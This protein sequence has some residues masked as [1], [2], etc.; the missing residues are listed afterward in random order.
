VS[1]KEVDR[2]PWP[3]PEPPPPSQA[4]KNNPNSRQSST[5]CD[6]LKRPVT[7]IIL[8]SVFGVGRLPIACSAPQLQAFV[9]RSFD[10]G[11]KSIL[12]I[13]HRKNL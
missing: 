13:S 11:N 12:N 8:L 9:L 4:V 5:I 2:V 6:F 3:S 1:V 7:I 10:E